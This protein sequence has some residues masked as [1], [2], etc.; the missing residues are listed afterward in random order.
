MP[1]FNYVARQKN[2]ESVKGEMEAVNRDAAADNLLARGMLPISLNEDSSGGGWADIDI[3]ELFATKK[4]DIQDLVMFSRQMY[5]LTK[6]G[7]PLTRAINGLIETTNSD[8]LRDAL[9]SINTDLSAGINLASAFKKHDHIFAPLYVSLIHVGENTGQLEKAF[10]QIA[11][12]L[13]LEQKTQQRIKS[14]TR[15]PMFVSIAIVLAVIVINVLVMPQFT[16]M[17]EAFNAGELP[18][19]TRILM[20]SSSF[21]INY[22]PYLIAGTFTVIYSFRNYIS[23]E[24]GRYWWDKKKLKFPIIGDIIYRSLLARF[25]RTFSMMVKS[26]VPLITTLN[27]VADVVDNAWVAKKVLEMRDGIEK[28]ESILVVAG[29]TKMFSPLV[30]Q[31]I[32]VGEETG[33][34]DDMLVQVAD[35]YEEQVDYDLKKLSDYI[36]PILIVFI[37]MIVLVLM[38]AIYLPMWELTSAARRG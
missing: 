13:E 9:E 20:A 19:P 35:F 31:M 36:E 29:K 4:V 15:Y 5:S 2:G 34:L 1:T 38:L 6:A 7:I 3:G 14:A 18:L 16:K 17:F 33:Q 28:G 25:S 27:I 24:K 11:N 30:L 37:G 8:V 12:Y 32:A 26:G 22:W 23:T 21:F 10:E